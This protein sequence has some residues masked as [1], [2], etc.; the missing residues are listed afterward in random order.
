MLGGTNMYHENDYTMYYGRAPGKYYIV[1]SNNG[2][3]W[4]YID[5]VNNPKIYGDKITLP[6][7]R[8]NYLYNDKY[9][10][11]HIIKKQYRYIKI[12]IL[13]TFELL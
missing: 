3:D 9:H 5:Y 11:K 10:A 2:E 1:G 7:G 12:L 6:H 13:K 4:D 8:Y